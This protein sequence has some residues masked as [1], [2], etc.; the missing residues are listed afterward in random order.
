MPQSFFGNRRFQDIVYVIATISSPRWLL[1][2]KNFPENSSKIK[3]VLWL[4]RR[5][6]VFLKE[7]LDF[8]FYNGTRVSIKI[9]E[10]VQ[11]KIYHVS[12][13]NSVRLYVMLSAI[14]CHLYI[15]QN[16]KNTHRGCNSCWVWLRSNHYLVLGTR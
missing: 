8:D 14:W 5:A 7:D 6:T 1:T 15:F 4:M 13:I 12:S 3:E 11:K 2:F 16:V 9:L 10:N